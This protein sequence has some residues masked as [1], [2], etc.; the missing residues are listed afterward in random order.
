MNVGNIKKYIFLNNMDKKQNN[1]D[2]EF[3]ILLLGGNPSGKTSLLNRYVENAFYHGGLP[4]IGI[5]YKI[6]LIK[7]DN[8]EIKIKILDTAGGE[9]F[10]S[11]TKYYYGKADGF[12][13]NFNITNKSSFKIIDSFIDDVEFY[14]NNFESI[15]CANFSDL[16]ER[17]E[18]TDE[19]IKNYEQE[20]NIKIFKTSAK[21]GQ[22]INEAFDYLIMQLLKKKEFWKIFL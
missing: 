18:I 12:I 20:I 16:Q 6:K 15:I 2:Y 14:K 11:L 7:I 9:R 1:P 3:T 17:K 21:T 22:G 10:K 8:Y 5:N 19:E 4:T 13:F